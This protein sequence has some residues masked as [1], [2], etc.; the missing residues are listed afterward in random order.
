MLEL[1]I[2]GNT[3]EELYAFMQ[4][5]LHK[6]SP[7]TVPGKVAPTPAPATP[8]AVNPIPAAPATV[9]T[10]PTTPAV[11]PTAPTTPPTPPAVPTAPS[12]E[13]H[14]AT[15]PAPAPPTAAPT[16][17]LE[18]LAQAGATL[19]QIGKMNEC[20]ALMKKYGIEAISQLNPD[21]FG[22]FATELRALGAQL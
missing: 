15:P 10:I 4:E 20:L 7:I 13:Q 9:A 12:V 16:Y 5:L 21:Q 2:K 14:P 6:Q 17:S 3:P 8:P 11:I 18:Q 1:T 22:A 19:V